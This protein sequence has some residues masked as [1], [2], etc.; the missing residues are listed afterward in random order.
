MHRRLSLAHHPR[1]T[2][3]GRE[4]VCGGPLFAPPF[5][6]LLTSK[7]RFE[8]VELGGDTCSNCTRSHWDY[9]LER[10][11]ARGTRGTT[12]YVREYRVS[13]GYQSTTCLLRTG[14]T[15]Q[16]CMNIH[17]FIPGTRCFCCCG[18]DKKVGSK[19]HVL[20]I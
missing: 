6:P 12:I 15:Y 20:V 10:E 11:Q 14:I 1:P 3:F 4:H 9:R 17:F 2:D 18:D 13:T 8:F 5:S 19:A 16:V 7:A